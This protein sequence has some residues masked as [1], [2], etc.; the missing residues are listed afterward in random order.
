M[1]ALEENQEWEA[2]NRIVFPTT[3]AE[4]TLPLYIVNWTPSHPDPALFDARESLEKVAFSSLS[5]RQLSG[6]LR[7]AI[8][9]A[10]EASKTELPEGSVLIKSR[11]SIELAAGQHVSLCTFFNA[12]P[13]SYWQRWTKVTSVHFIAKVGGIGRIVVMKSS[14]RGIP[15]PVITIPVAQEDEFVEA[16]INLSGFM[17]GGFIWID[18]ESAPN[19]SLTITDAQWQASTRE[20]RAPHNSSLSIAITTFN[21]PSYCL[22]QLQTIAAE[23]TLRDHLDTIYCVDQGTDR[24]QDQSDF[25]QTRELLG[26]QLTYILQ[27]NLG[28]SGGFSRGM[29]ETVKAQK[30]TYVL[31][32]DDDAITEPEAIL[33][34]LQFSDYVTRPVLVGGGMLHLDNRTVLYSSGERFDASSAMPAPATGTHYNHDF[35]VNPLRDTPELHKRINPDFNGWWL[36]LIPTEVLKK[37]GLSMPV[38]IK[39]DDVEFGLR[40]KENNIP[41]ICLPGVAVWHQAWHD[42]DISRTWEEYFAQRNRWL[43]TLM[44]FPVPS[45]KFAFRMLYEDA[46]L[47]TKLLYS[48]MKL[49]HMALRDLTDGPEYIVRCLP[50]KLAEVRKAR[51]GFTDSLVLHNL[52]DFPAALAD[53]DPTFIPSDPKTVMKIGLKSVISAFFS[54]SSGIKDTHPQVS[55]M[56]KDAIWPAFNKVSSALVTTADGNGA[57]WFKR[58]SKLYRKELFRCARLAANVLK[59]WNKLSRLYRESDFCSINTWQRIFNQSSKD[60]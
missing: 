54:R 39:Y 6:T 10:Q 53:Y 26:Q 33:R 24:V 44:H 58:D 2:V 57:A 36:C 59:Q 46:H 45:K 47:G 56:S 55:I 4:N 40:A 48:A 16:E 35:A 50:Q 43:C 1:S 34:A 23:K 32:L 22:K 12:F 41:T 51:E 8:F 28:G 20:R 38:F 7:N 18:M 31:L 3:D 25:Q 60:K 17:D 42:K 37:I 27:D 29:Y 9:S 49:N 19:N 11:T 15:S 21:R 5:K 52:D 13:A 30:S 14:A